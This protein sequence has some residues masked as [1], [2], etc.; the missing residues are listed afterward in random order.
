[1]D[2]GSRHPNVGG[3][4]GRCLSGSLAA[5]HGDCKAGGVATTCSISKTIKER[6]GGGTRSLCMGGRRGDA[7]CQTA[8]ML[9]LRRL[10]RSRN[11]DTPGLLGWGA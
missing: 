4:A 1:M 8:G 3:L 2:D 7:G 6:L 11:Q 9:R 5:T 10:G